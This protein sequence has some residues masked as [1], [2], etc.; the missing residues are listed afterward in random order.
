MPLKPIKRG[1][2]VWAASC[3]KTGYLLNFDIYQGKQGDPEIG[4]GERVVTSLSN[5]FSN[6][7]FCFYF[8]GFFSNIPIMKNM[9]EKNNFGCGTIKANRKCFPS[10]DLKTDKIFNQG[11]FNIVTL[12]EL[13]VSKWKDRGTKCVNV[14][15]NMH[16]T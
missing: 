3:S 7:G 11:E 5:P 9:L 10:A 14:V 16:D 8:D 4:L 13:S 15:S 6:K 2:K 12:K 1:I